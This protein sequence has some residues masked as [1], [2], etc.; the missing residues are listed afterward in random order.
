MS[1]MQ[2]YVALH[3][4]Y[5]ALIGALLLAC[6]FSRKL[7]F[8]WTAA[9]VALLLALGGGAFAARGHLADRIGDARLS[10]LQ[11]M[12]D[13]PDDPWPRGTGHVPL[14]P[15]GS[16]ETEKGYRR[17]RRQLQS[18]RRNVRRFVLDG[19]GRWPADRHQ[20]RHSA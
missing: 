9:G 10:V 7:G 4:S 14:G 8:R 5:Y 17:A 19:G 11:A 2:M 15:L 1:L 13:R 18:R 6:V 3:Y 12:R 20:R 16:L